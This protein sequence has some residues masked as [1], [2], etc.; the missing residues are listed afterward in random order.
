M[1]QQ[2]CWLPSVRS[3]CVFVFLH[4]YRRIERDCLG[5]LGTDLNYEFCSV[6]D[7]LK[8][9]LQGRCHQW[10]AYMSASLSMLDGDIENDD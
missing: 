4:I 5:E 3:G 10:P 8:G 1:L 2:A 6:L 9:V 7:Q